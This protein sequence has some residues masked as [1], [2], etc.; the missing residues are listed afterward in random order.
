MNCY[1]LHKSKVLK[2]THVALKKGSD[3]RCPLFDQH[4]IFNV[5]WGLLAVWFGV[6]IL[7]DLNVNEGWGTYNV[8]IL[9][10]IPVLLCL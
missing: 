3:L 4:S 7:N 1:L 10:Q 5:G 8:N 6:S 2:L 9:N